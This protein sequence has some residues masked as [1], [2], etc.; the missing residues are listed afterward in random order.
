MSLIILSWSSFL[1]IETSSN[2]DCYRI[3][4]KV[5]SY[6]V[7]LA[8]AE[9]PFLDSLQCKLFILLTDECRFVNFC[10][11]TLA[12]QASYFIIAFEVLHSA[13]LLHL[14]KPRLELLS[15]LVGWI[16]VF[17]CDCFPNAHDKVKRLV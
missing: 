9:H 12:K 1:R 16:E 7:S 10:E 13:V 3:N 14:E 8:L 11:V 6:E 4:K 15:S 17:T 2:R 5:R